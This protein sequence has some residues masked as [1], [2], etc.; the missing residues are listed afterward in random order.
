MSKKTTKKRRKTT[1]AKGDPLFA[2]VGMI[3][4]CTQVVADSCI[5]AI[6]LE[7]N[8]N[9]KFAFEKVGDICVNCLH[10]FVAKNKLTILFLDK[11]LTIN[12]EP[13]GAYDQVVSY[14]GH[15]HKCKIYKVAT[16]EE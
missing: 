8:Q 7:D 15:M 10:A 13:Q 9:A 4:D 14:I 16:V 1:K 3:G 2:S 12:G 5:E 11:N 6:R